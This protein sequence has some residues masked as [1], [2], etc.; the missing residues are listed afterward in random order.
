MDSESKNRNKCEECW[1]THIDAEVDVDSE[2][3]QRNKRAECWVT[4]DGE[5]YTTKAG[6]L[7]RN[8]NVQLKT[9][10]WLRSKDD[11][12]LGETYL[13]YT[14][15]SSLIRLNFRHPN[16]YLRFADVYSQSHAAISPGMSCRGCDPPNP[17]PIPDFD[18]R[19]TGSKFRAKVDR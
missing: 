12:S 9:L 11:V 19:S 6:P 2:S 8:F 3:K 18:G 17:R 5:L 10:K 13:I 1:V 15:L 4:Q 14:F 7:M 16:N